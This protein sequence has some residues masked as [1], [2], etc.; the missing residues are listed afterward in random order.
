MNDQWFAKALVKAVEVSP[1][2]CVTPQ[3]NFHALQN[4]AAIPRRRPQGKLGR[5]KARTSA[6]RKQTEI[7]PIQEV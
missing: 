2:I 5:L 6:D 1:R 3:L 7:S 4:S